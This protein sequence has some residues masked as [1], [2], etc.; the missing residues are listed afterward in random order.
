MAGA[1][2]DRD[3][4]QAHGPQ[5]ACA[6]PH[7]L[8]LVAD[9]ARLFLAVPM[10]DEA[11]LLAAFGLGPEGLAE[12]ALVRGDEPRGGREN[13]RGRAVVLFET[14][15][16]RAGKILLEAQ[17][18]AHLG[19][20]PAVDRLVVIA[21]AADVAVL[22]RQQPQPE[23]L[24][25][26]GVLV[27]IDEDI[28]EP[29]LVLR[30]HVLV[31]VEDGQHVQEKVAEI[32]RV[33]RP[34]PLLVL[35]V[36]LGAHVVEGR[37]LGSRHLLR[38]PGAVL[39]VVDETGELARGP[40]FLVDVGGDDELFEKP[41]LVVGVEDREVRLQPH[42]FG[43]AAQELDPD[44]VEGAEPGHPLDRFAEEA[45]HAVLHL[46]RGLVGEGDG[47]DLVRPRLAGVEKV[48]DPGGERAGLAGAR[49]REH[50]DRAIQRQHRLA[51]RRVQPVEVRLRPR[52]HGLRR[53]RGAQGGLEGVVVVETAHGAKLARIGGRGKTC[54]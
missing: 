11:D 28:A 12:A 53:E 39:P 7:R 41:H 17:D 2:E 29:A 9:P 35:G 33:E 38:A 54:S 24:G 49:A 10:A 36:Y 21:H 3:L 43:V 19:A 25:D 15:H 16:L 5:P 42:E 31:R 52:G 51:L 46:A 44:G 26:V 6:L 23:I 27:L 18:V 50:Q 1:H 32:H 47:Q 34:Q 8:D 48:R 13:V 37:S 40:A 22:A 20:A 30:Q 4:V 14:D 45:C